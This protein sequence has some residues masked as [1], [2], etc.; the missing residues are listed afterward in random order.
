MMKRYLRVKQ[1]IGDRNANPPVPAIIPIS[2]ST[3]FDKVKK[4]ELPKP[5]YPLGPSI[6]VWDQDEI[7][8]AMKIKSKET[9]IDE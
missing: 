4:G 8:H 2:R 3:F 1:I 5:T 7:L 6:A 9:T